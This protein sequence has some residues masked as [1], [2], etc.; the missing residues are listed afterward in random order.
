VATLEN[1]VY[2]I[3]D[4]DAGYTHPEF[5]SDPSYCSIAYEYDITEIIGGASASAIV[6]SED[7]F[8]FSY[9]ADLIP[10]G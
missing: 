3:T 9:T 6:R 5:T 1:Q 7:E 10:L 8:S 4:T 2:T